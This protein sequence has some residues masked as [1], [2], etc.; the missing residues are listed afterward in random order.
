MNWRHGVARLLAP[1]E[2]AMLDKKIADAD[3]AVNQRVAEILLKM[4]PLEPFLKDHNVI[5]SKEWQRPEDRLDDQSKL[6]LLSWAY[7][8]VK[9]PSFI[10]ITDFVRNTQG[11]NTLRKASNPREWDFGRSAIITIDLFVKEIQRLSSRY[12]EIFS[13]KEEYF[14]ETSTI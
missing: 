10:H 7:S 11:N 1:E 8:T 9:D 2:F 5:F 4:D 12:E 13:S 14:D 6:R 3:L